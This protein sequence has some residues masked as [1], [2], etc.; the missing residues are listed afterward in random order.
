MVESS[1]PVRVPQVIRKYVLLWL[2]NKWLCYC[3]G[4]QLALTLGTVLPALF[5]E[6]WLARMRNVSKHMISYAVDKAE[7]QQMIARTQAK[8]SFRSQVLGSLWVTQGPF[9][10]GNAVAAVLLLSKAVSARSALPTLSSVIRQYLIM[11]VVNDF[12]L[13]WGHRIQHEWPLLY[14][15]S[16]SLHHGLQTPTPVSTAFVDPLDAFLQGGLPV[17][18][19][20][21]VARPHPLAFYLFVALRTAE[22]VFNHSGLDHVVL[23]VISLKC[24]F[25][26]AGVAHHDYHHKFSG[27]AGKAKN[28]SESLWLWDWLFGT[29]ATA[30]VRSKPVVELVTDSA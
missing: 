16:H 30:N 4:P 7:R 28:Y 19:S 18:T 3:V 5:L 6:M 22:N 14:R 11:F 13:Y 1:K 29:L 12:V 17:M 10:W 26:R 2:R 8:V 21:M 27:H 15:K 23:N 25:G 20:A 24:L 9:A